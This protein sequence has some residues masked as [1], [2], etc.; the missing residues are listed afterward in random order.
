[1]VM[2]PEDGWFP[3]PADW[4]FRERRVITRRAYDD[5]LAWFPVPDPSGYAGIGMALMDKVDG[6]REFWMWTDDS[7]PRTA[8]V[9]R[10]GYRRHV[11]ELYGEDGCAVIEDPRRYGDEYRVADDERDVL[12]HPVVSSA[13]TLSSSVMTESCARMWIDHGRVHDGY[14]LG[15]WEN[16]GR[17]SRGDA[18]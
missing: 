5:V 6:A 11:V 3:L 1:M 14:V 8:R 2:L 15:R 4:V 9:I 18:N 13:R 17:A 16:G 10:L 12:G 7:G